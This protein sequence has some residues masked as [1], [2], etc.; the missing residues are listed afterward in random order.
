MSAKTGKNGGIKEGE[1]NVLLQLRM[2]D[3]MSSEV[4][5]ANSD[6]VFD[7]VEKY[8]SDIALGPAISL[9]FKDC[10]IE[11]QFDVIAKNSSEVYKQIAAVVK[12][13]EKHTDLTLE[14]S[15]SSVESHGREAGTSEFAAA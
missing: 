9:D 3:A 5:D 12:V 6:A 4:L 15:S 11:L 13:I 7:A 8:A 14:S 1:A 10:S 2:Q